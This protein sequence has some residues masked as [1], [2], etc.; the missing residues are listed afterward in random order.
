MRTDLI[1]EVQRVIRGAKGENLTKI[2][3]GCS[4]K[5]YRINTDAFGS[6]YKGKVIKYARRP[7]NIEENQLEFRTW[8]VCKR[9]MS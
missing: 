9:N 4:R 7:T 5:V 8:D 1:S 6:D 2:G 3:R